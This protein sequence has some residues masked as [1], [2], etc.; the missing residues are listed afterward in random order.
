MRLT[1][2]QQ[3]DE[4]MFFLRELSVQRLVSLQLLLQFG[5]VCRHQEPSR[6]CA[7]LGLEPA[8]GSCNVLFE[9]AAIPGRG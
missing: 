8:Q 7:Q 5:V 3:H 6:E 4:L 1:F 9:I 2:V